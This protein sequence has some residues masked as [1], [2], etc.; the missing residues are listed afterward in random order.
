MGFSSGDITERF[1]WTYPIVIAPTDPEHALRHLAARLEID[2]RGPDAGQRIS[3]DLTRH[4][5]S[6]LG[7]SGGPITLDQTGVE[8]YAVDLHARA[9]RRSTAASSGPDPTTGYVHVTRDGGK[10]WQNVTPPDLPEFTRISL[11][12]ASPHDAGDGLPRRQ[13]LPARRPRAVRLQDDR[14]RQDVDEDRPRVCRRRLRAR[15]PRRQEAQGPAV[16]RHRERHLRVVRRWRGAGSRCGS[17]CRSRQCTASRSRDDDLRHRD[18][19]PVV[20]HHGQHRGPPPD[21][22]RHD[23][24][25]GRAVRPAGRDAFGLARRRDRLLPEGGGRQAHDRDRSTRRARSIRTFTGTPAPSR[26]RTRRR[27]AGRSGRGR[28]RPRRAAGARRGEAGDEPV[29]LGHAVPGARDFPG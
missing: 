24:R 8:T 6:T 26:R 13:S 28:R 15:H 7:P 11:I 27:A 14:L 9:E 18:A 3:P 2:Q 5:P 12:E 17:T 29:H 1:Q 20:L 23:Q 25:A 4:D 10:N 16:P 22:P 21:R 19:R